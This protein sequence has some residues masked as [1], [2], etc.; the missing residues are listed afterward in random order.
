MDFLQTLKAHKGGLLRIKSELFWYGGHGWDNSPG[1]ICLVLDAA[2]GDGAH[3]VALDA[4][5]PWIAAAATVTVALAVVVAVARAVA[6]AVAVAPAAVLLL[7]DGAP[8][9]VWVAQ[10]DV[11][12]IA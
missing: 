4:L 9:W 12:L 1:R 10:A 7:I 5:V 6:P 3:L 11:E 8:H 2:A